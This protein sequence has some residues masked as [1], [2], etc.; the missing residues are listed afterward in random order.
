MTPVPPRP[1][2]RPPTG[3]SGTKPGP[4]WRRQ[5]PRGGPVLASL[6]L[7]G[8]ALAGFAPAALATPAAPPRHYVLPNTEILRL[9]APTL[10]RAYDFYITL[11]P[12]YAANPDR[13]YPAIFYTDAP[14]SIALLNGL[15]APLA[16]GD[17][18]QDAILVGLGY[19]AGDTAEYSRRRD[20]TP[21]RFGDIDA[22]SDMPGRPVVYGEA[23]PYRRF[24]AEV[25]L[26]QLQQRYRI[27]PAR[28]I[29]LG[30][31]YGAL[32]GTHILFTEPR[33]FR[34]YILISPSL[35]F[36][37]RLMLGRERGYAS[38]HHDLP[39]QV[40][41]LIGSRE[42]VPDPDSLA[43]RHSR[44]PMVEDMAEFVAA[45]RQRHY[46]GLELKAAV[47]PGEDHLSVV[48]P[49]MRAGLGWALPAPAPATHQPC[50]VLD[51]DGRSDCRG[52]F[53][54]DGLGNTTRP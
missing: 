5:L 7:T 43:H 1:L 31:S 11:P 27:D 34:K 39:A 13:R 33:M 16:D 46:P 38:R 14:R 53:T 19:A 21:S 52:P 3:C 41:F 23:E 15:T 40:F 36:A 37:Q 12:H 45:L 4:R 48:V 54:P 18:L 22:T 10:G 8:L 17:H 42:T 28:R 25:A 9:P 2:A 26:P 49:A 29:F 32:F 30:H 6:L 44:M 35:W 20:Y 47:L 50:P 24:L 51:A